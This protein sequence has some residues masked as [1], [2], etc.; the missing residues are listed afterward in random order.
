MFFWEK[1][2]RISGRY[3]TF[4]MIKPILNDYQHWKMPLQG[5]S[6][7]GIPIDLYRIGCGEKRILIW[8]QMHGNE[9]TTTLAMLDILLYISENQPD[10]LR[11]C[12]I[13]F[14]PMLN[15]DGAKKYIRFNANSVDLNRDAKQ[16]SQP[17]SQ[18]LRLVFNEVKPDFCFN[19]HGQR[20]IFGAGKKGN[21]AIISFLAPSVNP[22]KEITSVR[23]KTMEVI[24][25]I[26]NELQKYIPNCI[27][28]YNDDFNINCTGD[29]FMSLN[30]P[31]LLFEA[32]HFSQDYSREGVRK[33]VALAILKGI[34]TISFA[35]NQITDYKK[36][37]EIPQNEICFCDI[38]IKNMEN[39]SENI[40]VF[41]EEK[42]FENKFILEPQIIQ[43][44]TL[45]GLFGHQ[46]ISLSE[47]YHK[48]F[49]NS[50]Q[51]KNQIIQN[52]KA[53]YWAE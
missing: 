20:S 46:T 19:L 53:K 37:F 51:V 47:V 39:N 43:I 17:E 45:E 13:Y 6:V 49:V 10:F 5:K 8:S 52:I 42:L 40:A 35:E 28:R 31:T 33:Y 26:N 25:L 15:P 24:S 34:E 23:V 36:Y 30:V 2:N 16:L 18:F 50:E 29:M 32:G 21:P 7:E 38:F 12:T 48:P 4:E 27:G 1:D 3:I 14:I 11:F 44:G 9:S 41:F 22:Q